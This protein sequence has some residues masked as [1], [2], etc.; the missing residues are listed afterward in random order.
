MLAAEVT[1]VTA[2]T[3]PIGPAFLWGFAQTNGW[4]PEA[5]DSGIALQDSDVAVQQIN[6]GMAAIAC[7]KGNPCPFDGAVGLTGIRNEPLEEQAATKVWQAAGNPGLPGYSS[8][9]ADWAVMLLVGTLL[10][11][12]GPELTAEHMDAGVRRY[13]L[14]GDAEHTAR[15]FPKGSYYW[16]Q[17]NRAMY[18][19]RNA[20]S[21]VNGKAGSF[22]PIGD[23]FAVGDYPEGIYDE[24]PAR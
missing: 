10:Q 15:G 24:V 22:I 7:P 14:R 11:A 1:T 8:A 5:L 4:F 9:N 3:D 12:A 17:G 20:I 13:D 21:P 19:D 18:W 2:F 23:S 16:G 6:I